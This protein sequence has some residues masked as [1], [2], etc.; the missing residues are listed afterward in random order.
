MAPGSGVS[1]ERRVWITEARR[2]I[3]LMPEEK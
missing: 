3:N 1:D 2:T